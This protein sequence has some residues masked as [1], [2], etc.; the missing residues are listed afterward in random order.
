[1]RTKLKEGWERENVVVH[2]QGWENLVRTKVRARVRE[3]WEVGR[4]DVRVE[5][6]DGE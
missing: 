6:G 2:Q 1:V 5:G 4:G 3:E